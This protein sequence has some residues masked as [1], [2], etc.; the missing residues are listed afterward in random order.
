MKLQNFAIIFALIAIPLILVLTYYI[1][2]QVDTIALQNKYDTALLNALRDAV[3]SFE[4]NTANEDL[5]SVSDSLRTIIEA[6]NN[7]FFNTLATNLGLS[8]ASKGY[9][10]PYVPAILYTLYDGYYISSPTQVPEILVDPEE[11]AISVGDVGVNT[12]YSGNYSYNFKHSS[13]VE[14][15]N[16]KYKDASGNCPHEV[17]T[18]A[19]YLKYDD[20][21]GEDYGQL[22]YLKKDS[23]DTYTTKIDEAKTTT[24]NVLKTYMPYSARYQRKSKEGKILFDITVIYTLDNYITIEGTIGNIYYAKSGYLIP[25]G[26]ITSEDGNIDPINLLDYSQEDAEN[27]IKNNPVSITIKELDGS[28]TIIESGEPI[29]LPGGIENK[30]EQ[31][32]NKLTELNNILE[33]LILNPPSEMSAEQIE[34]LKKDLISDINT[35]QYELDKMSAVIYYV[36]AQIFSDWV[37]KNLENEGTIDVKETDLVAISNQDYDTIKGNEQVTYKFTNSNLSIFNTEKSLAENSDDSETSEKSEDDSE[38]SKEKLDYAGVAEIPVDS[39]FYSHKLNVIRNSI[40]Y[41]LNLAMSVYNE[42]TSNT[43]DYEMP[44]ILSEEWDK[45]LNNVSVVAFM[46]GYPCKLKTYNNYKIVSSTN[47][48]IAISPKNIFYVPKENFNDEQSEYHRIDCEKLLTNDDEN[49]ITE[50]M[51]FSSKEVKYDKTNSSD[52]SRYLYDHKNFACYDCV[53]DGNYIEKRVDFFANNSR[54]TAYYIAVGKEKNNLYKMNAIND[55]HGYEVIYDIQ[56]SSSKASSRNI[57]DIKQIE[58]VLETIKTSN[59]KEN[60]RYKYFIDKTEVKDDYVKP[61]S[62]SSNEP[63]NITLTL[64]LNPDD[65]KDKKTPFNIGLLE[66][67]NKNPDQSTTYSSIPGDNKDRSKETE[68]FLNAIKYVRVIYK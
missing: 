39:Q 47:N 1:Q 60:L 37:H 28:Q 33:D 29:T 18:N 15:E 31:L 19:D 26:V 9:V 62:I 48:E 50:Y 13:E 36:K 68:I 17:A 4:I 8:N 32:T 53:N 24:K 16:C 22:L 49:I 2:L 59:I 11:R 56:K 41:N 34:A 46:K 55:S 63:S 52:N 65:F 5:S 10:E 38:N 21:I 7:V 25:K 51:S 6:S 54:R 12:D 61:N 45:I 43:Y 57:N 66:V 42:Q 27:Y 35:V 58:I 30:Y 64:N 3:S 40:Q 23:T 14:K 67:Q 44:I 20:R